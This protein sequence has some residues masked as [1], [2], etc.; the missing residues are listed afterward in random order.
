MR[1]LLLINFQIDFFQ[2]GAI[3]IDAGQEL[4]DFANA[5]MPSYER[6][7]AVRDWHP[8]A[9]QS[10]ASSHLW[11]RPGQV[12]Q[13]NGQAQLLWQ[14]HC[15]QESFGAEWAMG[16]DVSNFHHIVNKGTNATT[17]GYSAFAETDLEDFLRAAGIQELH[18]IGM[19]REYD[20]AYTAADAATLGFGVQVIEEGCR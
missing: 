19:A 8:A 9:H 4:V 11:R 14:M 15:V 12:M 7:I 18:L 13:I 1:A 3:G 6:I 17:N 2:G 16:L 10:F 20:V 5:L